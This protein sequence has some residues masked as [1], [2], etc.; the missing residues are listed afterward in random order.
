MISG[1]ATPE[2]SRQHANA[3][4]GLV[5]QGHYRA[6]YQDLV[7]S[8]LGMGTYLGN[9]D[10]DTN[11]RVTEAAV[12]SIESGAVNV[13]DTAINYRYQLAERSLGEAIGHVLEG[14]VFRRD[15]LFVSTKVGYLTPDANDPRPAPQYLRE[16][17]I[18]PG[19]LPPSEVVQSCHS[20]HPAY[21]AHQ[22]DKS[23][24][25]LG[26]DTVDLLY[27]H[28]VAESQLPDVK[29]TQL[30][31]RLE[32]AFDTLET[33]RRQQKL[34]YYGLATW[35]CF[36]VH[37]SDD[38]YLSL[39]EVVRLAESVGGA[40]HGFRYIQ[41]PFNLAMGEAATE[42]FQQDNVKSERRYPVLR[43][44][45][46]LHIGVFTSVPLYQG[47]L[48]TVEGLPTFPGLATP[49]QQCLQAV[50]CTPGIVAPLVGHKQ[51]AHVKENLQVAETP[52]YRVEG[53]AC[54]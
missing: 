44:A 51:R 4:S 39:V 14:A 28:N 1:F 35:D 13:L 37:P 3:V 53:Q 45:E 21:L 7:L 52:I 31:A 54:H 40:N 12:T 47:N 10:A 5:A 19:I 17:L 27:L 49:A 23:R 20:L 11:A 16:E 36:R 41:V 6:D 2:G 46:S 48:L 9:P 29:R 18:E 30:M 33:A 38:G 22:L 34:Q 8:S 50:R 15:G 24:Q 42:A 32:A 25:N 26:L 43:V